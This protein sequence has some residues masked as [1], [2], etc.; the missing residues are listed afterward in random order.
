MD[1]ILRFTLLYALIW[2]MAAYA[3]AESGNENPA[4]A[5]NYLLTYVKNS[6]CIFIRNGREHTAK[7]AV[8]HMQRKYEHFK[9]EIK[10]PE[11]FIRLA[12][13]KSLMTGK[14]YFI[15][16]PDGTK[17]ESENWLLEALEIYRVERMQQKADGPATIQTD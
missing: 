10:S 17:L 5:I 7:A 11:D 13:T 12:A 4:D 2:S 8:A 14:P 6:D 16:T 9:D 15:E 3:G 1:K